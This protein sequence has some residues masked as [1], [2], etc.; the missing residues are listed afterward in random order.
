[1]AKSQRVFAL[2]DD[3]IVAAVKKENTQVQDIVKLLAQEIQN[4]ELAMDAAAFQLPAL[5]LHY[6][7]EDIADFC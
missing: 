5:S 4:N 6:D 3:W 1:M 7:I 2:M